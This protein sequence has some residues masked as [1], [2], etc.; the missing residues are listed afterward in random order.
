MALIV[1]YGKISL[2]GRRD[3]LFGDMVALRVVQRVRVMSQPL[4]IRLDPELDKRLARLAKRTGRTK[5]FYIKQA[6]EA[7]LNELEDIY[8]A[9]SVLQRVADGD[10]AIYSLED[11]KELL[12]KART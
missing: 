7:Q 4:S 5:S 11:A 9:E 3:A 2:L 10:E 8:L 6:I 12:R 1:L